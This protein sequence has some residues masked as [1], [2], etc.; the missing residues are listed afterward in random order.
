MVVY[1]ID[2]NPIEIEAILPYFLPFLLI[3]IYDPSTKYGQTIL[4]SKYGH[5]TVTPP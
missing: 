5:T 4:M 2:M 1:L 3:N